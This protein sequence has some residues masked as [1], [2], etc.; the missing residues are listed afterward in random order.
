[1]TGANANRHEGTTMNHRTQ[2]PNRLLHLFLAVLLVAS[3]T[4]ASMEQR[5]KQ[6]ESLRNLGEAYLIE[7]K[8]T[9]A[10]KELLNAEKLYDKDP[11]LQNDLGLTYMAKDRMDLAV[12]HFK[13]AV[14]LAPDWPN[15]LNNLATAY[16][17]QERWDLAIALLKRL[18]EDLLYA[19]PQFAFLNLGWAYYNK[20]D[21]SKAEK[22]YRDALQHYEDGFPKDG[23]YLKALVGL[24]RTFMKTGKMQLAMTHLERAVR[25]A[26]NLAEV[27]MI[28]A[29]AYVLAGDNA[30]A[31]IAYQR[32]VALEPETQL[33]E[34][35][36]NAA[37]RLK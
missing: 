26:P 25:F 17:K 8:T 32:V 21:Y 2:H 11:Y 4:S 20:A 23:T 28:L 7:N 31:R 16:L 27:Q 24:G 29:R 14:E 12:T 15:A 5:I 9:M 37:K 30:S 36:R 10:L 18:S 1:M 33:A 22:Y 35:A 6:S 13:K 3:C 19:T 34:E